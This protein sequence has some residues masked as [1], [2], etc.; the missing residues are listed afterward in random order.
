MDLFPT[1]YD[2]KH[3]YTVQLD[4][5]FELPRCSLKVKGYRKGRTVESVYEAI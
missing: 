5:Q 2:A 3:Y 1:K 4:F